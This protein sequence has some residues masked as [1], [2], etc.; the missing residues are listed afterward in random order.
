MVLGRV[1]VE[2]LIGVTHIKLTIEPN[3]GYFVSLGD[4]K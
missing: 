3:R 4:T 2:V 1:S